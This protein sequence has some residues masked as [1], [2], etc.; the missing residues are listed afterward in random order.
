MHPVAPV[1]HHPA[2]QRAPRL[3][4]LRPVRPRLRDRLELL[5]AH[6][7]APAGPGHGQADARHRGHGPRG[8]HRTERAGPR[9]SPTST[10]AT[11]QRAAGARA[12]GGARRERLRDRRGI[13][14]NSKSSRLPERARQLQRHGRP[15][16]HGHAPAP[17]SRGF[18]PALVG[19]PPHNE[20]GTGGMHLY[21]PWWLD[22]RE[23]RFPARLPHRDRRAAATCPRHGFMGGIRSA[24]NGG[25]YGQALKDDYRRLLRLHRQLR[26]PRRDDPER[27]QL[28]RDRPRG[29]GPLG[30]PG[31][32]VPLEVERTTRSIRRSTCRRPSARSSTRWAARPLERRCRRA[33]QNYGICERAARSSTRLGTTRMGDEPAHVGAQRVLP[34][35][36]REEPVRGRRRAVRGA[37]RT[38]TRPGPSW[39]WPG[40]RPST[41]S[42]T[43][44]GNL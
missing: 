40:A 9:A 37:A 44:K 2:A 29:G 30:H 15:L 33:E 38:R 18:I 35:P 19:L 39:R 32:A 42:R 4:L 43:R 16:P 34:G 7:A 10:R 6:R 36:R 31:A 12:S 3:P 8:H 11:G 1:H 20:D 25:G 13:L 22:N 17:T 23:A 5:V 41:S 14:L 24:W 26:R 27:G 28:L 21:M